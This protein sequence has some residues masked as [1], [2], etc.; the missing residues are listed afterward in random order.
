MHTVEA[1]G[2][3]AYCADLAVAETKPLLISLPAN[4]AEGATAWVGWTRYLIRRHEGA[5]VVHEPNYSTNPLIAYR[6]DVTT[7]VLVQRD[8]LKAASDRG[9]KPVFPRF[10]D[11][12]AV[13]A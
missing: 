3:R 12:L 4:L 7:S 2:Q 9:L 6:P 5:L 11:E 13:E 8:M 1:A 10:L